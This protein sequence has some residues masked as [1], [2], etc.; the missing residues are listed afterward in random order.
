MNMYENLTVTTDILNLPT[1][2]LFDFFL[3][4]VLIYRKMQATD[5]HPPTV[6]CCPCLINVINNIFDSGFRSFNE[7]LAYLK[8]LGNIWN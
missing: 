5:F 1:V 2:N 6:F 7:I 4:K 8:K 3:V